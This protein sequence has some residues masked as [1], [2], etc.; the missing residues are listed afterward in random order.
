MKKI[1]GVF[2]IFFVFVGCGKILPTGPSD[3]VAADKAAAKITEGGVATG[4]TPTLSLSQ[5]QRTI[6]VGDEVMFVAEVENA[7]DLFGMGTTITFDSSKLEFVKIEEGWFI[8]QQ[9]QTSFM[10]FYDAPERKVV[11]GLTS[12]GKVLGVS[13]NG[14]LFRITFKALSSGQTELKFVDTTLCNS[15]P[16]GI[17]VQKIK[18]FES[19]STTIVIE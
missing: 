4:V 10:S 1:V 6:R 11:L 17:G 16:D 19:Q 8:K 2:A 15:V 18:N 9:N 13:G 3:V 12:L 5:T 7:V 14:T